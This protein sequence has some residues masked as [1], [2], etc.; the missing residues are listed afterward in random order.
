MVIAN[1]ITVTGKI[2]AQGDTIR[3]TDLFITMRRFEK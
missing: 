1:Y 2:F 3:F